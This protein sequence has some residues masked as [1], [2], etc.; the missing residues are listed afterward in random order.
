M[1][2]LD[3]SAFA[4]YLCYI[5]KCF[6]FADPR[7]LARMDKSRLRYQLMSQLFKALNVTN[8]K[9]ETSLVARII[10]VT[11]QLADKSDTP[12]VPWQFAPKLFDHLMR[13]ISQFCDR[14]AS[15]S[16]SLQVSVSAAS[17]A[18]IH[19]ID[20]L[21]WWSPKRI[22]QK[23]EWVFPALE[24]VQRQWEEHSEASGDTKAWDST[25]TLAVQ[26]LLLF[27]ALSETHPH[28]SLES[29]HIVVQALFANVSLMAFL[30]L[31]RAPGWFCDS[32]LQPVLQTTSVWSQL[33][34]LALRYTLFGGEYLALVN[35]IANIPE[36]KPVD[37]AT[38]VRIFVAEIRRGNRPSMD[39]IPVVRSLWVPDLGNREQLLDERNGNWILAIAALSKVWETRILRIPP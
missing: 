35:A 8:V 1:P 30:T 11:A 18:R 2:S 36:W 25:A 34:R 17:L 6:G 23:V 4:T 28:P 24:F 19:V 9:V 3:S 12:I 15:R 7:I 16:D 27:L 14:F 31:C 10:N 37:P 20:H 38:W 13:Q 26:S 21:D 29:L 33:G 5:N 39:C 32:T 22:L